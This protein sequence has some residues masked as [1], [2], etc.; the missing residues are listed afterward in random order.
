MLESA[1][2]I[3]FITNYITTYE[4]KIKNLNS[5][6]LF[7][8]AKLFEMF[9]LKICSLYFNTEFINLN[10]EKANYPFVDLVSSDG[11]IYC[12]VS[13]CDNVPRKIKNTLIKI[14]DSEN[15]IFKKIKTVYFFVLNNSSIDNVVSF[16]GANKIG[17]IIF[18]KEEHLITTKMIIEKSTCNLEFQQSIY[19]LLKRD[20]E[21]SKIDFINCQNA[22]SDSKKVFLKSINDTIAGK[23]YIDLENQINE[24][25]AKYKKSVFIV[26]EAGSGK[27]VLCKKIMENEKNVLF[28]RAEKFGYLNDINDIWNFNITETL[29]LLN[30]EVYVYVD[31]LEF[32]SDNVLKLDLLTQLFERLKNIKNVHIIASCRNSELPSFSTLINSYN[33][34]VYEIKPI[35]SIQ[36]TNI[37]NHFPSLRAIITEQDYN[38]LL[39]N[40]FYLDKISQIPDLQ[41][42]KNVSDLRNYLW[43]EKICL[44]N[45][46]FEKIITD[47]VFDRAIN[48]RLGSS[49]SKYESSDIAKLILNNVILQ[50]NKTKEV[51]LKYDIFED[52]CF[53]QYIDK[54]FDEEKGN[55]FAFFTELEKMGRCIYRRYQ[56]WIENKLFVKETRKKFLYALVF[57]ELP[58]EWKKQTEIGIIKSKY[59]TDFFEE[60]ENEI[61][62]SELFIKFVYL[63]NIYGF[64]INY[65]FFPLN[66]LLKEAGNGRRC[67]VNLIA[68]NLFLLD[69]ES[70]K[71]SIDKLLV[72]FSKESNIDEQLGLNAC[73]II[74]YILKRY[75]QR[76]ADGEIYYS[77][78]S[79]KKY[80]SSLYR[81]NK[82]NEFWIKDFFNIIYEDFNSKNIHVQSFSNEAI[83]NVIFENG[84]SLIRNYNK[85]LYN[86]INLFYF[87]KVKNDSSFLYY[88]YDKEKENYGLNNNGKNYQYIPLKENSKLNIFYELFMLKYFDTLRWLIDLSNKAVNNYKNNS[89]IN[90]YKIYFADLEIEKVYL[91]VPEMWHVG[92]IESSL[93][94]LFSDLFYCAKLATFEIYNN[95][96][97]CEFAEKVK[98][99]I[100]DESNNIMCLSILSNF[101]LR[102]EK[103]LP[104]FCLD[105]ISNID[106]ITEDCL[107]RRYIKGNTFT[108][109]FKGSILET[110]GITLSVDKKYKK[111]FVDND[112]TEYARNV[113]IYGDEQSRGKCYK[114]LDYLYNITSNSKDEAEKF[115]QIQKMDFRKAS[116]Y[117]NENNVLF[118][119]PQITGEAEKLIKKYEKNNS[120]FKNIVFKIEKINNSINDRTIKFAEIDNCINDILKINNDM[121][122]YAFNIELASLICYAISKLEITKEKRD[123]YCKLFIN[124]ITKNQDLI[125][126]DELI[127][128]L[129][130]LF[131]QI[132][133]GISLEAKNKIKIYILKK[134]LP[135]NS[136]NQYDIKIINCIKKYL[137]NNRHLAK[138]IVSTIFML[139]KD[140]MEHQKFNYEYL[141]KYEKSEIINFEPNMQPRLNGVDIYI[142][143]RGGKCYSSKKMKIIEKYLLNEEIPNFESIDIKNYD[144]KV[145]SCA[146]NCGFNLDDQLIKNIAIQYIDFLI[147][148]C[149][150]N[151]KSNIYDI[152]GYY[153]TEFVASFFEE[154]LKSKET[155]NT[156]ISILFDKRAYNNFTLETISFYIKIINSLT[157][158][159]FDYYD[160]NDGRKFIESIINSLEIQIKKI[161]IEKVKQKFF[162]SLIFGFSN[163]YNISS[164]EKCKTFYSYRDK[165]F[166]NNM[167]SK[168]GH[169]NFNEMIFIIY[170]LQYKKLLPEILISINN[171]FKKYFEEKNNIINFNM[172]P[173]TLFYIDEIMFYSYINYEKEIKSD[174]ELINSFENIL[175]FL[176]EKYNDS[177]AALLLDEFR[178]H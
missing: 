134:L 108:N 12:Q 163:Y 118:I 110:M 76:S 101:G 81:L 177:K 159:Y 144:I 132:N 61:I 36:L 17:N 161:P 16:D 68:R 95:T 111:T 137:K 152:V 32:I 34:F 78:S 90:F 123:E 164:W 55:Y 25:D 175:Q 22:L 9:A 56:I 58:A 37:I 28:V 39:S 140:E 11:N 157:S 57:K 91:G 116:I 23:Y 29:P 114:I 142:E 77:F 83:E 98:E 147:E 176:I 10:I 113:Q 42:I 112:L 119:V 19:N 109:K 38:V 52:I 15:E 138:I 18:C 120:I 41:T 8:T 165:M 48:F 136:V 74:R 167:F 174:F 141:K 24:I 73:L 13:T 20:S 59:C 46:G 169:F 97:K 72:D 127:E 93:P 166:L 143:E 44:G 154:N 30:G 64:S 105:F 31:A 62:N 1:E 171:A 67:L 162:S 139:S 125:I 21:F 150:K 107:K 80:I 35:S 178:I 14:R 63:T 156:T 103:E 47:I 3:D 115:L 26:G 27:S 45:T 7:D 128:M 148:L 89:K 2:R 6:G 86:L 153:E 130:L 33:I 43:R 70:N 5:V 126:L 60:N 85:E 94:V 49:A 145:L 79:V 4:N 117:K 51:R 65:S 146:F 69:N 151:I 92:E 172:N 121:F 100:I 50:D 104:G 99:I 87:E 135:T 155:S 158:V 131:S 124:L 170:K 54:V 129:P 106:L 96:K 133:E 84:F 122:S 168:Y 160:N 40:P 82:F 149:A 75:E 71:E 66:M 173:N 53:E 102:V 88:D